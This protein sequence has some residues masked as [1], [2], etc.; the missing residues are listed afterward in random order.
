MTRINYFARTQLRLETEEA[1]AVLVTK[2]Y[3]LNVLYA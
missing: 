3:I 2:A 1:F